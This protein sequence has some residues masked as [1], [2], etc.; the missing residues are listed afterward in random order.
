M[1]EK[2][3]TTR[4][5]NVCKESQRSDL[6][7]PYIIFVGDALAPSGLDTYSRPMSFKICMTCAGKLS[8]MEILEKLVKK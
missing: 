4:T 2:S 6:V 3:E 7:T 1:K 8:L 5:C